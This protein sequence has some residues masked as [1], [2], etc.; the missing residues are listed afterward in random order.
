[1]NDDPLS[2]IC[3]SCGKP[4]RVPDPNKV[5]A[6]K[7]CG[8]RVCAA[9]PEEEEVVGSCGECGADL[10]ANDA[11]CTE[12][13]TEVAA[14]EAPTSSRRRRR[15]GA[16]REKSRAASRELN[17]AM[18]FLKIL[19]LWF[20][21]SI[22]F[23]GFILA[24]SPFMFAASE[25]IDAQTASLVIAI[26]LATTAL[27]IIGFFQVNFRPFV[28]AVVLASMVTLTRAYDIVA[29]EYNMIVTV[30][31]VAWALLFW[32][33][34]VPTARIRRLVEENPDLA[35]SKR[36][37]GSRARRGGKIS[38]QQALKQA[39]K[40]AW[41]KALITV[42]VVAVAVIGASFA[43]YSDNKVPAF[44]D[45]WAEFNAD[46]QKG[47]VDQ[48]A[49]WFS[50]SQ[51]SS[52]RAKLEAVRENRNWGSSWPSLADH[53]KDVYKSEASG[54]PTSASVEA[55]VS[56]G[57]AKL[58]FRASEGSWTLRSLELPDPDF[59]PT[60][61]DWKRAWAGSNYDAMAGFFKD[62]GKMERYFPG[63]AKRQDWETLPRITETN[64]VKDRAGYRTVYF[65]TIDGEVRVKFKLDMDRWIAFNFKPPER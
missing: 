53:E 35:V 60:L 64:I 39:E 32:A 20:L 7:A 63:M 54:I 42:S 62:T 12:C 59:E 15:S 2:A 51:R 11:F 41:R 13:G 9:P 58:D 21:L 38:P 61:L 3:D 1:M 28:W 8:G 19:R 29:T 37:T 46:W 43:L 45:T 14:S 30:L 40:Q 16:D 36:I 18:K 65:K 25:V 4:Y 26:R 49:A 17:K 22:I 5:Y 44:E 23:Q 47:D 33:L 34:V 52:E 10:G 24:L 50:A 55:V 27:M 6:C 56:G 48:V 57:T 31:S